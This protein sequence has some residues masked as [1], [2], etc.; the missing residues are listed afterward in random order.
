MSRK[1]VPKSVKQRW[2]CLFLETPV[3][4]YIQGE[5]LSLVVAANS[6]FAGSKNSCVESVENSSW[7]ERKEPDESSH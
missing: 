6:Y 3:L 2:W 1:K 5:D 4:G 7:R